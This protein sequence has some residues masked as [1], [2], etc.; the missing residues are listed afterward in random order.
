MATAAA[1]VRIRLGRLAPAL[2]TFPNVFDEVP[3]A[4]RRPRVAWRT[5]T[6]CHHAVALSK[7]RECSPAAC[8]HGRARDRCQRCGGAGLCAHGFIRYFC[9]DC[10]G[11][12][13]GHG[14][15]R[16][17]CLLCGGEQ[18]CPHSY[19]WRFCLACGGTATCAHGLSSKNCG[20]CRPCAH[21]LVRTKCRVCRPRPA[22]CPLHGGRKYRCRAC[23]TP[24]PAAPDGSHTVCPHGKAAPRCLQC[25]VRVAHT[26]LPRVDVVVRPAPQSTL[27]C[28]P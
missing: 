25:R 26:V 14:A 1:G 10:G 24:R 9:R 19:E 7:C 8:P 22:A 15:R 16:T 6:T 18:R 20:R 4:A 28:T 2:E 5:K 13:C 21:G 17:H 12:H 23:Y 11:S 3:W 27:R